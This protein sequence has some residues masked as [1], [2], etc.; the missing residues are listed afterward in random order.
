MDADLKALEDKVA[1]MVELCHALRKDNIELRQHLAQAQS[2]SKQLK[3][4]MAQAGR[5]IEAL[6][7]KLPEGAL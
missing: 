1:Q 3:D 7:E 6:I 2:D 4:Q 5:R